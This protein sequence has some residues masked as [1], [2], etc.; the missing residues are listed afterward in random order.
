MIYIFGAGYMAKEYLKVIKTIGLDAQAVSKSEQSALMIE[1][2]FHVRCYQGGFENFSVAVKKDDIAVICT[3]VELLFPCSKHIIMLGFKKVLIEKPGSLY[4]HH[5]KELK[6][7]S[8]INC[9]EVFIAYNRRFFASVHHLLQILQTQELV[10]VN[11]EISEWTHRIDPNDYSSE[12]L[13][14]W[15]IGNT[16]H[17]VDLAFHIAGVPRKL[18]SCVSGSLDWHPSACRFIGSGVTEENVLLSYHGYWDSPGRWSVECLTRDNRYILRPMEKLA[19]Q[20]KGSIEVSDVK[21]VDYSDDE[22]CKPG[23]LK[24]FKS[25]VRNDYFG[26]CSLDS[27]IERLKIYSKMANYD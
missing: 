1:K 16:S 12:A 7:I 19:V 4:I 18:D 6:E 20:K 5:L 3:P 24:L 2:E 10:A 17:V 23:L 27:Q 11:L 9:A 26:L 22:I 13:K 8:R 15:F 25:F 21:E 14:Y